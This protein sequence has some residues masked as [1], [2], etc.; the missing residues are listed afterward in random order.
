M[1]RKIAL[2]L[3]LLLLC[4]LLF[5]GCIPRRAE[6]PEKPAGIFS[7]IWHGWI[8]P[9]SLLLGLFGD[10]AIY[11]TNN[12]GWSYDLG[13]YCSIIAGFGSLALFRRKKA[14]SQE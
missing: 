8:A 14:R 6:H 2:L 7:G 1:N 13:F 9:L 10:R 11:E 3:V 12:T 4:T 5:S